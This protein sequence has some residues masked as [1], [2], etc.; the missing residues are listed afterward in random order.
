MHLGSRHDEDQG[1]TR[2]VVWNDDSETDLGVLLVALAAAALFAA[3][4]VCAIELRGAARVVAVVASVVSGA[5]A[6][7]LILPLLCVLAIS[8][9]VK[10]AR[11]SAAG[12]RLSWAVAAVALGAV[13]GTDTYAVGVP[14][15]LTGPIVIAV[16]VI[17]LRAAPSLS[18][19]TR[20]QA[21]ELSVIV[22]VVAVAVGLTIFL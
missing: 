10:L 7:V 1:A 4:L 13:L 9:L 18:P 6:A 22:A 12:Q 11:G 8:V 15:L 21:V 17:E 14:G 5:Y 3:S 16:A 2:T 20:R 19:R